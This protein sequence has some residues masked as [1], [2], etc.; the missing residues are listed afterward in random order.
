M[1]CTIFYENFQHLVI[2]VL[3]VNFE[4]EMMRDKKE[5]SLSTV[6]QAKNRYMK[7]S[8]NS[9]KSDLTKDT[10]MTN[11]MNEKVTFEDERTLT[12]RQPEAIGC[13]S[14]KKISPCAQTTSQ[15]SVICVSSTSIALMKNGNAMEKI[16]SKP[17]SF[18]NPSSTAQIEYNCTTSECI[19]EANV[20]KCNGNVIGISKNNLHK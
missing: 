11:Y 7:F 4:T 17:L 15:E 6:K 10:T 18:Q 20:D 1:I 13:F 9:I 5:K 8:S 2:N 12:Q 19:K 14:D 3:Q 16:D